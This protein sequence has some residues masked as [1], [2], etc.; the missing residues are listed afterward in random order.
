MIKRLLT[1]LVLL[2]AAAHFSPAWSDEYQDTISMFR[3]AIDDPRFFDAAYGYAVFPTVGKGGYVVGGA[4]GTGRVYRQGKYVGDTSL[5]QVTVG[6][7]LGGQA[8]SEIIF[9]KDRDAFEKFTAGN[10]EFGA[11]ASAV[12][13][14]PAA[15]AQVGTTGSSAGAS[16][17]QQDA[18]AVGAY[19]NGTAVFTVAKGGLMY[20][21]SIG[22]QKFTY[23]P[24]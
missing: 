1:L 15:S 6:L 16:A 12:A 5:T 11:D 20:E 14:V 4:Y 21:A 9:F 7:Q 13:I 2:S 22:G 24:A 19:H 3:D 10:F 17:G 23:S 8:Y 18:R